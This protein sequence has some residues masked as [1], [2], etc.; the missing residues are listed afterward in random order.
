MKKWEETLSRNGHRITQP[1]KA[2]MAVLTATEV[3]LSAQEILELGQARHAGLGLVTVY[4]TLEL[5][6]E[7]GLACRVHLPGG[8]HG[9]LG[10]SPG[11]HHQLVCRRCGRAVEFRGYDDLDEVIA[12]L[13]AQTGY[14]IGE[15]LLQLLGLCPECQRKDAE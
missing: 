6:E 5:F 8:C 12:Q 2:V 11:H 13:E 10:A 9:F 14:A 15:H 7:L 4:R 1:R 3:P